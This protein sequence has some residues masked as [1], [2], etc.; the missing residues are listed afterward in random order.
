MFINTNSGSLGAARMSG[1][2]GGLRGPGS[3]IMASPN[4]STN[5]MIHQRVVDTVRFLH[6]AETRAN[7]LRQAVNA[8]PDAFTPRTATSSNTD[9]LTIT[10]FTGSNL[11][12]K[13]VVI[14]Q[15]ATP[16][17]NEGVGLNRLT[18]IEIEVENNGTFKF[19]VEIDGET[20]QLS[21]NVGESVTNQ[22]FQQRMA[23]A[24]NNANIGLTASV[25]VNGAN[26][27]LNIV[28]RTTGAGED[29]EPRFTLT[30]IKGNA[31][32]FT[33]INNIV[34]E[35]QDALFTVGDGEQQSSAS[36]EVNLG[37]GLTVT[38]HQPSDSEEP[39]NITLGQDLLHIQNATRNLVN[40]F[41]AVL[42]SATNNSGDSRTR[43]LA[44]QLQGASNM[45]RRALA[46][47]GITVG[48]G[49]FLSINA[50]RMNEAAENG[51][52]ERFLNGSGGRSLFTTRI[53][54]IAD[55]LARNPMRHVSAN[56]TRLPGF[57]AA[58]N[59]ISNGQNITP[60]N[61][62]NPANPPNPFEEMLNNNDFLGMLFDSMR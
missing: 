50:E 35:G 13:S 15:L 58:W 4:E 39:I 22:Q 20:H 1:F 2:S 47:I 43:L 24:I 41:N 31:T 57:N 36:N 38:F 9:A 53:E 48:E 6:G 8:L 27:T 7:N 51:R 60:P 42:E 26:S 61:Q 40:H 55:N 19:E 25:N 45:S 62:S 32:E 10:R 14:H 3:S 59:A 34:Q 5:Q 17:R 37:G 52:L 56:A 49:G 16:Q 23:N 46:D 33:G 11:A 29:G 30:D 21:F 18:P 28:T 12:D 54:R 44:R